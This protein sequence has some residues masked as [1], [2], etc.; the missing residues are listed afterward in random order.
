LFTLNFTLISSRNLR[1]HTDDA[2][3][4][5]AMVEG[6]GGSDCGDALLLVFAREKVTLIVSV[7]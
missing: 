6:G 3:A 1:L 7:A 4:G 5:W 2:S